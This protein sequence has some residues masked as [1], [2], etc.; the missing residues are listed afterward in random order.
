METVRGTPYC[1]ACKARLPSW[2]KEKESFRC[3]ECGS[4]EYDFGIVEGL[5][6]ALRKED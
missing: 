2:V 4:V 6:Y 3:P 1:L 5:D